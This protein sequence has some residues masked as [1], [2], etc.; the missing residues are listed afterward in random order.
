MENKFDFLEF[1][2]ALN[3]HKTEVNEKLKEILNL[4]DKDYDI[5]HESMRYSA[6]AE[7]KC[8]RSYIMREFYRLF[9]PED[10]NIM[11]AACAVELIHAY[12]LIHD[13]LP[14]MD[15]DDMRR[16]QP[17]NHIKF[18]EANA[19]LAGDA[20]L[21]LAFQIIAENKA[22]PDAY[23]LKIV[24]ETA[25][26]AGNYGMIG[27][28]V[29]DMNMKKDDNNPHG[30]EIVKIIKMTNLKTGHLFMVSAR[31]GCIAAGADEAFVDAATEYAKNFGLAFQI[32]DDLLD[33]QGDPALMGKNIGS[34][35]KN[36]K[37][38]FLSVMDC[39]AADE[40]AKT[41]CLNAISALDV[42]KDNN[43]DVSNLENLVKY[44]ADKNASARGIK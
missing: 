12:S 31:S 24:A 19:L 7:G 28:Q 44:L 33:V 13:D 27:G 6:L 21:T 26:A 10:E 11:P 18:G 9:N 29:M 16:G 30:G 1:E 38:N 40:Y 2:K 35:Q 20:L 23:N 36:G 37:I 41:L 3:I 42:F 43:A 25:K 34:D 22:V 39:D 4:S 17:S 32:M 5:L 14:C 15:D 8:V